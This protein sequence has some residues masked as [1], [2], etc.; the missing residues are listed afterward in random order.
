[1]S[2]SRQA[3]NRPRFDARPGG[4]RSPDLS[5]VV[6]LRNE[7]ESLAELY[8]QIRRACEAARLRFEVVFVDDGSDDGSFAV[9]ESLH[10]RD[11]RVRAIQFRRNMGKSEAL[12]AGFSAAAGRFIVTL[13]ADLQDDPAEIP[14]LVQKLKEGYDLVSGW[15]RER[16]DPLSKRIP[17]KFFNRVTALVS[18]LGIHDFNCGLKIYRSEVARSVPIYGEL[19]RYI[20]ALAKWEGFRVGE[21]PVHHRTRKYG[22]S[23][24]GP[25]R[26]LYGFLDLLT[27]MFLSRYTRRPLHLFGA[28]GLVAAVAGSGILVYLVVLRIAKVSYLSNRPILFFGVLLLLLGIQFVSIGL[29]GEMIARANAP[30]RSY[31]VRRMLG[32]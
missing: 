21:L 25:S 29:L 19:H 23:K 14:A 30:N 28:A 12:S 5:V 3:L 24:Y 8:G 18:G 16:R 6:P 20:P 15:K 26:F 17:S 10:R 22:K 1:M 9:L 7:R 13:D 11:P 4:S 31:A 32:D 27:V 2:R